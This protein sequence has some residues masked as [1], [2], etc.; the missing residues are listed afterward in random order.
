PSGRY[1]GLKLQMCAEARVDDLSQANCPEDFRRQVRIA[2]THGRVGCKVAGEETCKPDRLARDLVDD[3]VIDRASVIRTRVPIEV[4][5]V[6]TTK[7]QQV[8]TLHPT[9]IVAQHLVLTI[10]ET[11]TRAL[12]V[13]VVGYYG[14]GAACFG[15]GI[16]R[17]RDFQRATK[18]T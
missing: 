4:V 2:R 9:Y 3:L 8:I 13:N 16:S 17:G 12:V 14:A 15:I 18:T 11:L 5:L 7:L 6:Q 1:D 10:P